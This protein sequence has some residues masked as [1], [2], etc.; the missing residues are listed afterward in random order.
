MSKSASWVCISVLLIIGCGDDK[1]GE[2]SASGGAE[3][4][5][6]I[7]AECVIDGICR[8]E[9]TDDPDCVSNTV[10]G[11]ID[12]GEAGDGRFS[13]RSDRAVRR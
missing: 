9:C 1:D 8:S 12:S 11:G 2:G 4:K 6:D 5:G 7:V 10:D 3:G 13:R